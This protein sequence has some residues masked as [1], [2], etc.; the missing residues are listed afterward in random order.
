MKSDHQQSIGEEIANAISHG[1]MAIF[2]I[3]ALILLLIKSTSA[4]EALTA[5]IF[6]FGII[7]LYTMST[8]YHALTNRTAKAVMRRFD[9]LSIYLLIGGTFAPPL[10]L[11]PGLRSPF[12]G[13]EGMLSTGLTLFIVQWVLI[14]I[15]VVF[16][17]IWIGRFPRIHVFFYLAM[18]WS[19]LVFIRALIDYDQSAYHYVLFGGIAYTVGV[20]FYT[21]PRIRYF[22]FVWH[23][24][25]SIGTIL[26]FI[27][28][29]A[30]LY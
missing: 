2:G 5:T 28:I 17:S 7:M 6:A 20:V 24:F 23:V 8:L 1:V 14:V 18:G 3:V 16:K 4:L 13:I 12:L 11:L 26:Q 21:M 27:A 19:A 29:Y 25:T 22:H 10:L 30:F 9:H 15:G